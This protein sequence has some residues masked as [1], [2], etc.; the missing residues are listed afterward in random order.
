MDWDD[1]HSQAKKTATGALDVAPRRFMVGIIPLHKATQGLSDSDFV[2][3]K[4]HSKITAAKLRDV[5][6]DKQPPGVRIE[7]ESQGRVIALD[8]LC[9]SLDHY[10]DRL[11]ILRVVRKKTHNLSPT[12]RDTRVEPQ[13]SLIEN[14][15]NASI[16]TSDHPPTWD[17]FA[18]RDNT[19]NEFNPELGGAS[20]SIQFAAVTPSSR[21]DR[22]TYDG[23]VAA[24]TPTAPSR[25]MPTTSKPVHSE[26]PAGLY[27]RPPPSYSSLYSPAAQGFDH[28]TAVPDHPERTPA[29]YSSPYS[30]SAMPNGDRGQHQV[31][32]K[33]PYNN[34]PFAPKLE[35]MSPRP[36]IHSIAQTA[37]SPDVEAHRRYPSSPAVKSEI[38][39]SPEPE[40]PFDPSQVFNR[41]VSQEIEDVSQE[42]ENKLFVE[43]TNK[44]IN[45]IMNQNEPEKLERGVAKAVDVLKSL[46]STFTRHLESSSDATSW[47][48]AIEKL[49]D[50]AEREQARTVI[51]VVGN[52]GAGKSSVINAL[53]DE[54]RLVPTNCMRACTAVVT[55]IS[56]NA[57]DDPSLKYLAEVQFI[58]VADWEK[59]LRILMTE[60]LSENGNLSSEAKDPNSDAGVALSKFRAVY[61]KI[62]KDRLGDWTVEELI[63]EK[64]VLNCLGTTKKVR[65]AY[66]NH[67]YTQLQRFVD[68]KEKSTGKKEKK[69]KGAQP[70]IEYWPLIK[71]VRIFTKAKALETGAVVVD[72]PGV[73]DSNAARAA[74]AERYMKQCTGLWIVA[75]ITRAVD[76]KAAKNLLGETFKRQLKYDG[77]YSNVTF[78]CSKTDDISITEATDSL[79][80]QSE[81]STLEDQQRSHK[82]KLKSVNQ[83]ISAL[84]DS[85][86]AY[87]AVMDDCDK[88]LETWEELKD[89]FD[90]G[91]TVYAPSKKKRNK[92]K[93]SSTDKRPSKR[94]EPDDSDVE[95]ISS[96]DDNSTDTSE[97]EG[98]SDD[99][100]VEQSRSPLTSDEIKAKIEELRQS[101]KNARQE[102]AV[103]AR[104]VPDLKAK[105]REIR[106]KI[107]AIRGDMSALCIAGRNAYS[108][109]AIQQDF[110]AGIRELDMENA[111][112][113]DEE[114]FNPDEDRRDYDDVARSLPVFCVSSRA[115]QKMS[116]RLTKDEEVPGFKTP[117]ETEMPQLQEHCKRL[118]VAVRVQICRKFLLNFVSQLT[119]FALW[120]S[121][122]GRGL[123]MTAADRSKQGKYL[124][125]RLNELDKG[126][127]QAVA[128]CV[129]TMKK[130]LNNQ[131][132][133]QFPELIE[134]AVRLAPQ[135]AYKWGE[136]QQ[137]GLVWSTY[138]VSR[139]APIRSTGNN[140]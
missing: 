83:E 45:E 54:E 51:G 36:Y 103:I 134:E 74:V 88:E 66:P 19:R 119:T 102:K 79:D 26:S 135:T 86:E 62:T 115:Y 7:L 73:H 138:K 23:H 139:R 21:L 126:F 128:V 96:E 125:K 82:S 18:G 91:K 92:R 41:G 22:S 38:F 3:V 32:D 47:V 116:G 67:F 122:D 68:S 49:E 87:K 53:L 93:R 15:P 60:F 71:E 55:S 109:G 58:E 110:A 11:I 8:T 27:H 65:S 13:R 130:E 100:G 127:E 25:T 28:R 52:T 94:R 106:T 63:N 80:L 129:Q 70:D 124:Q 101:K 133:K 104:Q 137:G 99:E 132:F 61:P 42:M 108:K 121:N 77:N 12:Q 56:Y 35:N 57:N 17:Q 98:E 24:D 6:V 97:A 29:Q 40:T 48:Q 2:W 33:V 123:N 89:N 85:I 30:R 4:A 9:K 64:A 111:E 114:N 81:I 107:T 140:N 113:E 44:Y 136:K 16:N 105:V 75:P 5:Y 95:Y 20:P 1:I 59:E 69:D 43:T 50:Q 39:S 90:D 31:A 14:L 34:P 112:E 84:L 76:D 118:T 10:G 78:I 120:A 117:E 37:S 46:K 72:L 131:I